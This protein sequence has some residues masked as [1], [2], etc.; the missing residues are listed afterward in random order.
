MT[1]REKFRADPQFGDPNA[2]AALLLVAYEYGNQG[3]SIDNPV[4]LARVQTLWEMTDEQFA[5]EHQRIM[6]EFYNPTNL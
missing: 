6:F 5:K 4:V 3:F 1:L 2:A